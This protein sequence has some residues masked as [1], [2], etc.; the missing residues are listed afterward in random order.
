MTVIKYSQGWRGYCRRRHASIIKQE[1]G[2]NR[3]YENGQAE[4]GIFIN[5]LHRRWNPSGP[6]NVLTL[7]TWKEVEIKRG[8]RWIERV[9]IQRFKKRVEIKRSARWIERAR[10]GGNGLTFSRFRRVRDVNE[11]N[12]LTSFDLPPLSVG[13]FSGC[14]KSKAAQWQLCILQS[15]CKAWK[16]CQHH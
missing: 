4:T 14:S 5:I 12:L 8:A 1:N 13:K 16:S 11:H 7:Q 9:G 15:R 2:A 10:A 6:V 3:R